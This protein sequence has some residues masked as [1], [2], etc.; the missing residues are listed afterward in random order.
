MTTKEKTTYLNIYQRLHAVMTEVTYIQK[1]QKK[2]NGQYTF[3]K[4]DDVIAKL[5]QPLLDN[6]IVVVPTVT[7]SE[8]DGNR[9]SVSIS[10]AFVC[11]DTPNDRFEVE[12]PGHGLDNQDKGIG[13]AITYAMKYALLKTFMLETGDEDDNEAHTVEYV[14]PVVPA[15][16]VIAEPVAIL[17][18]KFPE[19]EHSILLKYIKDC[20]KR[21]KRESDVVI[22]SGLKTIDS[23]TKGFNEWKSSQA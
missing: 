11:I 2:M 9:T 19:S 12:Y 10:I 8:Q 6:G 14:A 15:A 17:L 5:R 3:V 7:R 4:A 22:A 16:P 1:C 18:S 13:K 21:F 23:F 20:A